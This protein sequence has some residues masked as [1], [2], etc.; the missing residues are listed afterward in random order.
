MLIV[1]ATPLLDSQ[2]P[3]RIGVREPC[4]VDLPRAYKTTE[5][6]LLRVVH[7]VYELPVRKA[8]NLAN[9]CYHYEVDTKGHIYKLPDHKGAMGRFETVPLSSL[10]PTQDYL[11]AELVDRYRSEIAG[12]KHAVLTVRDP[13]EPG[14]YELIDGHHAAAALQQSGKESARVWIAQSPKDFPPAHD[15]E[16]SIQA[17]KYESVCNE[18]SRRHMASFGYTPRIGEQDITSL[19]DL[20]RYMG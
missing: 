19:A 7:K 8:S 16:G 1:R 5:I 18:I 6:N 2:E 17:E 4:P 15:L 13:L 10:R 12:G 11:F 9:P 14:S 20:M 3:Y